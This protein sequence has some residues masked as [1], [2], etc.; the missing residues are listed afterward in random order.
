MK[1]HLNA[2]QKQ[3]ESARVQRHAMMGKIIST[4]IANSLTF[5]KSGKGLIAI[6]AVMLVIACA[7]SLSGAFEA[8][9]I[10]S[11]PHFPSFAAQ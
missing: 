5:I 6:G 8:M 4:G 9:T 1:D 10:T 2:V 11:A 7:I 3:I